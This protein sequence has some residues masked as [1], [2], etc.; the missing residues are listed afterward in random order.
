MFCGQVDGVAILFL[1]GPLLTNIFLSHHKENWL[2]EC[3]IA[4]NQP[5]IVAIWI[6][7]C[8]I[9]HLYLPGRSMINVFQTPG[10]QR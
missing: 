1:L 2:K 5:F 3:P 8:L 6:F 10:C 7:L 9:N 4:L